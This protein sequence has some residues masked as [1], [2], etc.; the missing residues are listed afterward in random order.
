MY[1][2]A[3]GIRSKMHSLNAALDSEKPDILIILESQL[4]GKYNIKIDGYENQVKRNRTTKGGGILAATRNN[5]DLEMIVVSINEKHEQ[6]C[7][8]ISNSQWKFRL[9][10]AYGL[11]ESRSSE[12]EIDDWYYSL[13][14]TVAKNQDE[15]LLIVGDIN[16]HIGNDEEGI[17]NNTPHINMNG[18][19]LRQMIQRRNLSVVNGSEKCGLELTHQEVNP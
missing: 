5:S 12:D 4:V 8:Q 3:R 6:M 16:A 13:E 1:S 15:Q 18:R 14:K 11:Q 9:C 19:L 2:N 7:L 17:E 10:I